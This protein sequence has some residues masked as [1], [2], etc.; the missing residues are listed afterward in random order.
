MS[1]SRVSLPAPSGS[2]MVTSGTSSM[3]TAISSEPPPMS[4]MRTFPE[5]QPNHRRTARNVSRASS[6]PGSTAML[7]PVVDL[8]EARTA[9]PLD[10]SRTAEVAKASSSS[11]PLSSAI[12]S[13]SATKARSRRAQL[14]DSFPSSRLFPSWSSSLWENTG[15]GRPP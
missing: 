14:R 9:S 15:R 12:C 8:T 4:S 3:P 2:E 11:T 13:A 10:A 5:D 1:Q 6:G 7:T